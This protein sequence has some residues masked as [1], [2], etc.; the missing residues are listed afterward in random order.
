MLPMSSQLSAF[1]K[2]QVKNPLAFL[3]VQ[4]P[5]PDGARVASQFVLGNLKSIKVSRFPSG[6]TNTAGFLV[7][8]NQGIYSSLN[9]KSKYGLAFA[10]GNIDTKFLLY[11]GFQGMVNPSVANI[12]TTW[13]PA[14]KDSSLTLN[15]GNLT[16]T[17]SSGNGTWSGIRAVRGVSSGKWYW[18]IFINAATSSQ[19]ML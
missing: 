14:D 17:K 7:L 10:P 16:V 8:D 3:K 1:V 6:A 13:N 18:E 5:A 4:L 11:T 19:V 9:P 2:N 12:V 15:T